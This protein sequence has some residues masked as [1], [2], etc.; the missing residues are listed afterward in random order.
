MN[1]Q[2]GTFNL[3]DLF[4][5]FNLEA[6]LDALPAEDRDIPDHLSAGVRGAGRPTRRPTTAT[7]RPWSSTPVVRS[8]GRTP[9]N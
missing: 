7:R 8:E 9:R 1:V 6:D 2:I 5:Q 3:S 4:D